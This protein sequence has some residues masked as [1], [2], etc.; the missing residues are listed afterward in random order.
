MFLAIQDGECL[1]MLFALRKQ[2]LMDGKPTACLE[3]FDWHSLP[4]LRGSG[5]GIRLMRAMMHQPERII[6]VGGTADVLAALP[7]MGWEA[8]G[9]AR[10][11]EL[12]VF[13]DVLAHRLRRRTGLPEPVSRVALD[14][15]SAGYFRPRR[16]KVPGGGRVLPS[17]M[18]PEEVR[19]LYRDET[20][21]RFVQQ[22]EPNVLRWATS[23]AWSGGY[24]FLA[25]TIDGQLRGWAMT[26]TYKTDYGLGAAILDVFAPQP[27][28]ALYTWMVSE[29]AT[30]LMAA[31]PRR[32]CAR[33]SCPIL[34]AALLA[35]HFRRI[36]PDVPIHTWP[37]SAGG[38]PGSL[39]ITLN[40][41][42]G[43]LLPYDTE[44]QATAT[45]LS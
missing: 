5:I 29:A 28:V 45:P 2:Y 6:S 23:S 1:G 17:R 21:Y 3:V 16:R 25:F 30:S 20:G 10:V 37:K 39:H 15:L 27:D 9:V 44:T 4:E 18:L 11:F 24:Q 12:P 43:W 32:L 13:G 34:Q 41:S 14:V 7:L 26:R 36:A 8:I 42:D 38:R 40:H 19:Q 35:N 22:P 33:A 31:L